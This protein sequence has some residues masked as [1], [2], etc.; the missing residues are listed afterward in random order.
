MFVSDL[1]STAGQNRRGEISNPK[2]RTFF[3]FAG[4]RHFDARFEVLAT[5]YKSSVHAENN[6][7]IEPSNFVLKYFLLRKAARARK[8]L[9]SLLSKL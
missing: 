6:S 5:P 8:S 7:L 9:R 1:K 2:R 4:K 3:G